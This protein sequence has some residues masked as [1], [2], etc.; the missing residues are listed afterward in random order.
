MNVFR[1]P[2]SSS[3]PRF[4][5][6]NTR[7]RVRNV[8]IV[9]ASCTVLGIGAW[10]FGVNPNGDW[11]TKCE[12]GEYVAPRPDPVTVNVYNGTGLGGLAATI[13]TQ[14]EEKGFQIGEVANDP[15]GRKI[16]GTG[17]VRYGA[18]AETT[19]II[20]ALRSWQPGMVLV[21]DRRPGPE[22]DFVMGQK[23]DAL[24]EKPEPPPDTPKAACKSDS[25]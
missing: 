16:R 14:L 8:S 23:F 24:L 15:I 1:P 12:R 19:N 18:A 22:V 6:V 20:R 5:P 25:E 3:V 7:K 21:K 11:R 2:G 13:K 9:L 10:T 17:E 4:R